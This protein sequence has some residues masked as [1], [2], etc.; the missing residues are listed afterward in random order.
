MNIVRT[1]ST[2]IFPLITFPYTSRVLGPEGIGKVSFAASFVGYFILLASIGIPMY[3]IRE[4]A[5]VRNDK[6]KLIELTQEL[7][8]MQFI[9]SVIVSL[10]FIAVV[11]LNGKL[12]DE[13]TLFFIV[14]LSIILTSLGME[15]FYQ[16]LEQYSYIT[17]RSIIFSTISTIAIFIFIHNKED[18][19]ISAAITVFASLGSSVLNFY[20]A[21]KTLFAKRTETWDF[22]RHIKPLGMVYLMNFIIS[23]YIQLDMVMLGFMSTAKNVGYYAAGLKLNRTLLA[24][25]TSLGVVLLPR[26]SYFIANDMNDEFNRM[27]KKSFEVIWIFCLPI[28]GGMMLLSDEI[29]MLFAGKQYLP[30]SICVIITSPI[31]LFIGLTNIFGIQIL[32]PMGKDKEVVFAVAVGAILSLILNLSLIPHFTYVG[33]AIATLCSELVV[34]IV[35]FFL[36]AKEYRMLMPFKTILKYLFATLVLMLVIFVIKMEIGLFWLRLLIIVPVGSLFYFGSLLIMKESLVVEFIT[37]VKK[38]L[39]YV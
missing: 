31:I 8:V 6:K 3:G 39:K 29:I 33:A 25:V 1:V 23:I 17:T 27:L 19:I 15:W 35:M 28:V 7:F 18:Y 16:G 14:S 37:I 24:L 13:K 32:Y 38:R 21:R 10:I 30:A 9:T 12:S 36:I 34:L 4:I 2:M 5:R 20:N 22:K 11:F 26:L